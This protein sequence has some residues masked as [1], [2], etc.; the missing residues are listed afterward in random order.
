M[1]LRI[2]R[3]QAISAV[4]I[5]VSISS[6]V[7]VTAASINYLSFFPAL[8][9][10]D[11]RVVKVVFLHGSNGGNLSATVIV[12]NPTDYSGF[13]V[14]D[15]NMKLYL[16]RPNASTAMN[17]TLFMDQPLFGYRL[18]NSDLGPH[19]QMISD[20]Y[21]GL[22]PQQFA[23]LSDFNRTYYSQV[24]AQVSLIVDIFTFLYSATG[25]TTLLASQDV[26]LL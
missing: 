8:A 16:N 13:V 3:G 26:P 19:S 4:F 14:S 18:F 21:F 11:S 7:Y 24:F 10:L 17:Q 25:Y 23:S 12:D 1:K 22:S 2:Q 5:V 9:K 20:V 15:V 6:A